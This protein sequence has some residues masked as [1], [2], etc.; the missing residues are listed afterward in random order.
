MRLLQLNNTGEFSLTKDL[1]QE[2]TFS[3]LIDGTGQDKTGYNKIRFC[4]Q[5]A[6]RDGLRYFWVDTCCI[7]KSNQ[8]VLQDAINSMFRWYQNAR[9][10][11]VHLSD[12][13]INTRR[14]SNKSAKWFTRGWT[15]QELLAPRSVKF[16]SSEGKFLGTPPCEFSVEEQ[17][18]WIE[19]RQTTRKEDKAY[20]LLGMFNICMPLLYGEGEEHA[21]GRLRKKITKLLN[22]VQ[23]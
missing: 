15:L 5:Q 14:K 16:F 19:S 20:S 21:F 2:V 4:R 17:F 9:E 6:E 23:Q 22:G 7:D 8:V 12:V 1:G 13:S 3:D 18:S 10:C 11:Y